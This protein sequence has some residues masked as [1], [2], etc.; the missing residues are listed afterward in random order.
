MSIYGSSRRY[1]M[2][3]I[4]NAQLAPVMY[5][6]WRLRFYAELSGSQAP[7]YGAVPP[8]VL[9]RLR[10]LGA[11]FHDV[12][13]SPKLLAPML[14]RFTVVDDPSV[15]V[16]IVRDCDSRLTPRD[17]IVVNDWLKQNPQQSV[18]HCIRDHPSHSGYTINGGLWGGRR[19]PL[20]AIFN[21]R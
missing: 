5:P 4:R 13:L 16:F 1:T 2:G 6:G 11:E 9:A 14:W 15:D 7:K 19:A 21:G 18:L 12:S 3:A 8:S 20:S 17:V 10:Q